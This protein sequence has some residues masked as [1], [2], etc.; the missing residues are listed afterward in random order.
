[1]WLIWSKRSGINH[2]AKKTLCRCRC[3]VGG[4]SDPSS[5]ERNS[6]LSV[7]R[8]GQLEFGV[9]VALEFRGWCSAAAGGRLLQHA[10]SSPASAQ[11]LWVVEC[12]SP[13][14]D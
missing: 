4:N 11:L 5:K 2:F 14:A 7:I 9:L 8:I 12:R 10:Q 13:S 6:N 1:M 3:F